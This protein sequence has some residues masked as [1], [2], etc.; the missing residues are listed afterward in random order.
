MTE[1]T[2]TSGVIQGEPAVALRP[3]DQVMRLDRMGSYFQT[4]I[5]FM[6]TLVRRMSAE[7]WRFETDRFDLDANGFG[8]VVYRICTPHGEFSF[9]AFSHHLDP[10]DRTDRVIAER[11]DATFALREGRVDDAHLDRLERNVPLQETG[12]CTA[13]ELVL[14]RANKSVRLFEHTVTELAAGR[15]PDIAHLAKTGYLMRTTAVYGNGKF[16]L[17][18]F[19]KLHDLPVLNGPF[20]AEMLT[21]F[22]IRHFSI[23]LAE[24]VARARAPETAVALASAQRRILGIGNATGL[25]MAPF[26]IKH[27][28]LIH[29]WILARET[30][31]A[32]VRS[33]DGA[34]TERRQRFAGL[35]DRAIA[36]VAEWNVADERQ[37]TR[38]ATLQG[39]LSDL[40]DTL[41]SAPEDVLPGHRPWDH[42]FRMIETGGSLEAQELAVSLLLETYAREVTDLERNMATDEIE[43]TTPAMRLRALKEIVEANYK[44]ALD[45]DFGSREAQ[46]HFWY[47]SEEKD[48]PRRGSRFD[49]PGADREMRLGFAREVH[50]LYAALGEFDDAGLDQL[51]AQFLLQHPQWRAAVR[52][53]QTLHAYPYGEIRN[54][55]L[56]RDCLPIDLLRCK[57]SFFGASKWDP[58]SDL[59]TRITMYQGAPHIE[60][61]GHHDVDDWAFPVAMVK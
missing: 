32:R 21:V 28:I 1:T 15:Q 51:T 56:A 7:K 22:M 31:L 58:K 37:Q 36:H 33:F 29:R 35:M 34:S 44:W 16:G 12:R 13:E 30:A 38:I 57:L 59:W 49:E 27:P 40:H 8:R 39:E 20:Q 26:L 4:P 25:G 3:P 60:D 41:Q 5:S 47:Y 50:G 45:I 43:K 17:C 2:R 6:R 42:F 19:G 10:E 61:L 48:E 14:S 54:N 53:V 18:D 46:H 9:I 23:A 52:R 55:L 11:W 24:H